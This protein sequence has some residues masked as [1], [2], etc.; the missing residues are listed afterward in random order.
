MQQR[1]LGMKSINCIKPAIVV[2]EYN[3]RFGPDRSVTIPYD[4]DFNRSK[5]TTQQFYFW[6]SLKA[7]F[8]LGKS[9]GYSLVGTNS[10]GCN[11]FFMRND[12]VSNNNIETKTP[13]Y[14]NIN[15]FNELRDRNKNLKARNLDE[16]NIILQD[17]PLDEV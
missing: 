5:S 6:A 17:L 9:K 15:S 3:A 16:E 1:L 7:L 2:I 4:K 8:N 13:S 10:N 12:L 14:F 11:A